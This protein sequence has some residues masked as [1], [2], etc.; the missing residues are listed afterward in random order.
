MKKT[1]VKNVVETATRC[2][3]EQGYMKSENLPF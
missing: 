3:R 1:K 2:E